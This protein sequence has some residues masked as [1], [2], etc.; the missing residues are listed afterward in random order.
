MLA[1]EVILQ[2][3]TKVEEG[4]IDDA[5]TKNQKIPVSSFRLEVS[6]NGGKFWAA[7]YMQYLIYGRPPGGMP[8]L[9]PIAEW[10]EK[11]ISRPVRENK[12][13]TFS[14]IPYESLA[15]AIAKKIQE[16]GT[17]IWEGKREGI[18]LLGIMESNMPQ[19]LKDLASNEAAEIATSLRNAIR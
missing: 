3:L 13:G 19:F 9:E 18:D 5:A 11:N 15:F 6:E 4:I 8:P 10:A 17:E 7:H 1:S 12:D 14:F 16:R 2:F